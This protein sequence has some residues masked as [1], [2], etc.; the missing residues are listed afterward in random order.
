MERGADILPSSRAPCHAQREVSQKAAFLKDLGNFWSQ[1][2][3][4]LLRHKVLPPIVQV[5][6]GGLG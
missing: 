1:F 4:R 6:T 3:D 5:C 2:D